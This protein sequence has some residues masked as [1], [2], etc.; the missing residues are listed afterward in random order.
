MPRLHPP[1][2][3]WYASVLLASLHEHNGVRYV[4]YSD[5][6]TSIMGEHERAVSDAGKGRQ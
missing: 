2:V 6:A 4:R 3:T 1:A 5:L